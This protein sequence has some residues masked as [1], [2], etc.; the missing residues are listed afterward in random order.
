MSAN[1]KTSGGHARPCSPWA[2]NSAKIT[3]ETQPNVNDLIEIM[4]A[5]PSLQIN[6]QGHTD[7]T[8]DAAANRK[9]SVDRASAVRQSLVAAG[10]AADRVTAQGF[11]ADKPTA[12]NDNAEGR[13]KNRRIDVVV[14]KV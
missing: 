11:G 10:V 5:Y 3:G 1:A 14:T 6:I 7:N 13:Q 8:G 4:K 9:L 2:T 12:T